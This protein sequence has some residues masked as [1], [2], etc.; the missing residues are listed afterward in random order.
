[1]RKL[2]AVIPCGTVIRAGR[3]VCGIADPRCC[4]FWALQLLRSCLHVFASGGYSEQWRRW[5]LQEKALGVECMTVESRRQESQAV[6]CWGDAGGTLVGRWGDVGRTLRGCWGDV[7][8]T[9][10]AYRGNVGGTLGGRWGDV[11]GALG[12]Y[13][14]DVGGMLWGFRGG[15]SGDFGRMWDGVSGTLGGC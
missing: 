11:G 15:C 6:S 4:F 10:A 7:G 12:G 1:M 5:Q 14:G 13:W 3:H 2:A 9:L 8:G